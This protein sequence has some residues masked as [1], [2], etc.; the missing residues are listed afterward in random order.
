M[1]VLRWRGNGALPDVPARD[2]SA[3]DIR[4]TPYTQKQLLDS[5]VYERVAT[6]AAPAAPE[7]AK[8]K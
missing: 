5:G 3:K 8:E 6:S 1:I 2:L 4:A 7:K